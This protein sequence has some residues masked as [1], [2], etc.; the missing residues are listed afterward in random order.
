MFFKKLGAVQ[1]LK[2]IIVNLTWFF[3]MKPIQTK[4]IGY[5]GNINTCLLH[6]FYKYLVGGGGGGGGLGEGGR[7]EE[8]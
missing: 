7:R 3:K 1:Q 8:R 2:Q 6:Q 5:I 4:Y